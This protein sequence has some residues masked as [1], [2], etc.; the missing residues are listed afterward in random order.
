MNY[1][2]RMTNALTASVRTLKQ[3]E[4]SEQCSVWTTT[5]SHLLFKKVHRFIDGMSHCKIPR[6]VIS[7]QFSGQ[8]ILPRI[9]V[10][11]QPEQHELPRRTQN[12][13]SKPLCLPL[14]ISPAIL[15]RTWSHVHLLTERGGGSLQWWQHR[16]DR[17]LSFTRICGFRWMWNGWGHF[18]VDFESSHVDHV[19]AGTRRALGISQS[20]SDAS[21][22]V[23]S[24][25]S[26]SSGEWVYSWQSWT[27]FCV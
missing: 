4:Y 7:T 5:D 16:L 1:S 19:E 18:E 15:H 14:G 24:A 12:R 22:I 10:Q 3:F 20:S 8:N 6:N 27:Y 21:G 25:F 11:R 17:Q 13:D 9:P 23:A 26:A 2:T